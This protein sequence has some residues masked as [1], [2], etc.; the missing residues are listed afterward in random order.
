MDVEAIAKE[1]VDSA[2][3]VHRTLGP[4]LFESTY[5]HCLAYEIRKRGLRVDCEVVLPILYDG[6][7]IESGYRLDMLVED[8]VVIENKTVDEFAPIHATQLLTYLRMGGF[9]VGF[10]INWKVDLIKNGIKRIVNPAFKPP[11]SNRSKIE[12]D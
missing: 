11:G 9:H 5:Q 8:A 4:G 7:R 12:S 1:I 2:I 3:K 10:L 6:V